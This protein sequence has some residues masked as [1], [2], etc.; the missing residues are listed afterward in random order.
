MRALAGLVVLL[1]PIAA[2]ALPPIHPLPRGDPR[3]RAVA[4]IVAKPAG[5]ATRERLAVFEAPPKR[6]D[7]RWHDEPLWKD[8]RGFRPLAYA[9]YADEI[10]LVGWSFLNVETS[11]KAEPDEQ[12]Y[13]AGYAEGAATH[14][15]LWMHYLNS[16]AGDELPAEQ[17]AFVASNLD[18][19]RREMRDPD[20][21]DRLASG[22]GSFRDKI[23]EQ[24]RYLL[25]Q[26]DGMS[27]GYNARRDE[28][29]GEGPLSAHD[30]LRLNLLAA[31][32]DHLNCILDP[33]QC[34]KTIGLLSGSSGRPRGT[35]PRDHCTMMVKP[36]ED[37][38]DLFVSHNANDVLTQMTRKFARY[39]FPFLARRGGV[40]A[41]ITFSGYPGLVFS[42]D[43]FSVS[44]P[45]LLAVTSTTLLC[46][47][48]APFRARTATP[49]RLWTFL[50]IAAASRVARN[51]EEWV[52]W[53]DAAGLGSGTG[54][55]EYL[56]VDYGRFA[57]R[58]VVQR[59]DKGSKEGLVPKG[60]V[61]LVDEMPNGTVWMD[62]TEAI[63]ARRW[64]GGWNTAHHPSMRA[65]CGI[66][67]NW[68]WT[69]DTLGKR[70]AD[71]Q[72]SA[73]ATARAK[74]LASAQAGIRGHGDVAR[75]MRRNNY[76]RDQ[77]SECDY[78]AGG[79]SPWLAPSPRNDLIPP[80]K[81]FG[82]FND[83]LGPRCYAAFDNKII[84][85]AAVLSSHPSHVDAA[86]QAE[87]DFP[88]IISGPSTGNGVLPALD[89]DT[90]AGC[91]MYKDEFR[92]LP[93]KW[94]FGYVRVDMRRLE[95]G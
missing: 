47:S 40:P 66:E 35:A 56:V 77:E 24:V 5:G 62:L 68:E 45:S 59:Q 70:T 25:L 90:S 55:N 34:N 4:I 30:V 23:F 22:K 51:G 32:G 36:L 48:D 6:A 14:A 53:F 61:T 10:D 75:A 79:R 17:A 63:R 42:S 78:C 11:P 60:T 33:I 64:W 69:R 41:T 31:D 1:L 3:S 49:E 91:A 44:H 38:S 50:R 37:G 84:N 93:R 88:W 58:R 85:L 16:A 72:Y 13:A 8:S 19:M 83:I 21:R 15:R 7:V 28:A 18:W 87:E 2:T 86:A 52:R 20:A 57:K 81:D 73:D 27:D 46:L 65:A 80:G 54:L 71:Q 29:A 89:L 94:E 12:A 43:D 82:P 39:H 74:L 76:T 95:H 26:I 67:R 9:G 92:G